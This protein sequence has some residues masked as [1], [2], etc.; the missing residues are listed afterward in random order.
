MTNE[1]F[2]HAVYLRSGKSRRINFIKMMIVF[3]FGE[4]AHGLS[5]DVKV[6]FMQK[7]KKR[8]LTR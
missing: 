2:G 7:K 6:S 5:T 3:A 1:S 8:I 4:E